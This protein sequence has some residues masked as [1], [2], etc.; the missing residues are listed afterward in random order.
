M[1]LQFLK[2]SEHLPR[3]RDTLDFEVVDRGDS[4]E[5]SVAF[6][7]VPRHCLESAI[8]KIEHII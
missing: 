1:E 5:D 7:S 8:K 6:T 3:V 4:G 2:K